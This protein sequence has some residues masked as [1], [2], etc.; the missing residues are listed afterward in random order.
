MKVLE[1]EKG[2]MDKMPWRVAEQKRQAEYDAETARLNEEREKEW[3]AHL[4]TIPEEPD[5][6]RDYITNQRE[7]AERLGQN[8]WR[9]TESNKRQREKMDARMANLDSWND[10]RDAQFAREDGTPLAKSDW[11]D[12]VKY[13]FRP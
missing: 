8:H 2:F 10:A 7:W 5:P 4:Q 9:M 11:F 12:V 1:I 13:V 3:Q 6:E